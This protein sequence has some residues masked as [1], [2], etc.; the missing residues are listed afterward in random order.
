MKRGCEEPMKRSKKSDE[1]LHA[2]F[3]TFKELLIG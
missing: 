3:A 2:D 1:E